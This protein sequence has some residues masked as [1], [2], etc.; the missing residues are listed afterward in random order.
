MYMYTYSPKT[1]LANPEVYQLTLNYTNQ[2]WTI[3][4]LNYSN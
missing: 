1:M 2:T 4:T 3:L